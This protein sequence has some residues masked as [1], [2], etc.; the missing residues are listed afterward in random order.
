[1]SCVTTGHF[2]ARHRFHF[3]FHCNRLGEAEDDHHCTVPFLLLCVCTCRVSSCWRCQ[4]LGHSPA[5]QPATPP[6]APPNQRMK[7][8][9]A[10]THKT[11][12]FFRLGKLDHRPYTHMKE[13]LL[14]FSFR[15]GS[16]I[17]FI[18]GKKLWWCYQFEFHMVI[19]SNLTAF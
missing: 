2:Q 15:V 10:H 9:K 5:S 19:T 12:G 4:Q 13:R 14:K 8:P 7:A 11:Y 17:Q 18:R 6:P 3:H 16:V 1:M